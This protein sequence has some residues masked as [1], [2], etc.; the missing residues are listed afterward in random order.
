LPGRWNATKQRSLKA[1]QSKVALLNVFAT[2]AAAIAAIFSAIAAFRQEGAT[3]SSQVLNSQIGAYADLSAVVTRDQSQFTIKTPQLTQDFVSKIYAT[4]L[5][6]DSAITRAEI[7]SPA[8]VNTKLASYEEGINDYQNAI[9][10][11]WSCQNGSVS[12]SCE[13]PY[14]N[15]QLAS[16]SDYIDRSQTITQL[17]ACAIANLSQ[18]R[19]LSDK[20]SCFS[21]G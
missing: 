14:L 12:K 19:P 13:Q 1:D 11:A 3:Y 4:T 2:V 15:N 20:T 21:N 18:G 7:V 5:E 16:D 8:E 6:V 9:S 10:L 17:E